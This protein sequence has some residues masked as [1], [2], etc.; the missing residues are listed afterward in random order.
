MNILAHASKFAVM[1]SEENYD[2]LSSKLF[3]N[4]LRFIELSLLILTR[5]RH[6]QII[7]F[8][9]YREENFKLNHIKI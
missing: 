3:S 1:L 5:K 2:L 4:N 9:N 6:I 8:L 7:Y